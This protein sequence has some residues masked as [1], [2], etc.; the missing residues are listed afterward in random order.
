MGGHS[1]CLKRAL[2]VVPHTAQW[3]ARQQILAATPKNI[4]APERAARQ[5]MPG[6]LYTETTTQAVAN[7]LARFKPNPS[8]SRSRSAG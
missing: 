3:Q 2:A 8:P 7:Y 5:C 4:G 6:D 1:T